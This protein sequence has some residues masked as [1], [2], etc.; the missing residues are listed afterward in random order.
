MVTYNSMGKEPHIGNKVW[1]SNHTATLCDDAVI[2]MAKSRQADKTCR[3][4]HGHH[5][6]RQAGPNQQQAQM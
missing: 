6:L 2:G 1:S 3:Q 5:V 4:H